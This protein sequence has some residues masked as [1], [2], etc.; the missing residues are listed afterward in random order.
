MLVALPAG[1]AGRSGRTVGR[2]GRRKNGD[3]ITSKT[4]NTVASRPIAMTRN[5]EQ[6]YLANLRGELVA[7]FS[8]STVASTYYALSFAL[9]SFASSSEYTGLFDQYKF[10]QIEVW[11]EPQISQ[12]TVMTNVGELV[13]CIDLDDANTPTTIATVEG[14]Q[15]S[16]L[17]GSP[18]GHYHKW[19][20]HMAVAVYSGAF[21]SFGNEPASWI[22]VASPNVQH[23]GLKVGCTATS[24]VVNF[25]IHYRA[26]LAFR[27][28]GV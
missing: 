24:V 26:H 5:T 23:Y 9:S 12:S 25:N 13:T 11:M 15:N 4:Y 3:T 18:D 16:L 19:K 2:K 21:T 14:K 20:P 1:T 17:T 10:L 22:D 28:A 27:Q 6:I 7:P 8:S